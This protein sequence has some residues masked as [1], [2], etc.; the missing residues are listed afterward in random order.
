LY[1]FAPTR[2]IAG[3]GCN[4]LS[5][6]IN[7][8]HDLGS[9]EIRDEQGRTIYIEMARGDPLPLATQVYGGLLRTRDRS[10]VNVLHTSGGALQ[11][12]TVTRA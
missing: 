9:G 2:A 5:I 12:R 6:R 7:H 4:C 10:F 1:F 3:G 8:V 11:W